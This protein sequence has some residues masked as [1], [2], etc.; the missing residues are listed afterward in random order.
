MTGPPVSA[1]LRSSDRSRESADGLQVVFEGIHATHR[2][3]GLAPSNI[4][5]PRT[6][7]LRERARSNDESRKACDIYNLN[8]META[9]LGAIVGMRTVGK[10]NIIRQTFFSTPLKR[11]D[12]A[13]ARLPGQSGSLGRALAGPYIPGDLVGHHERRSAAFERLVRR[14]C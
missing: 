14:L 7:E 9:R 11:L 2:I 3:I 12:L 8:A 10:L 13:D 6:R 1:A 5:F 4:G